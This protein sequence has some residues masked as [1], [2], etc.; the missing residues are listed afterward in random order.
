MAYSLSV[1][2]RDVYRMRGPESM[3]IG[4]RGNPSAWFV[5]DNFVVQQ[6][7]CSEPAVK[8]KKIDSKH[9]GSKIELLPLHKKQ[10]NESKCR[11]AC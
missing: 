1:S 5:S 2:H 11:P 7:R 4:A 3:A 8:S 6:R 10:Y 9:D